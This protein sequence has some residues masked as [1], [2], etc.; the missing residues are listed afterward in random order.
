MT[1]DRINPAHYRS[2]PIECIEYTQWLNFC[3]G[4]AFKY[5]WRHGRKNGLE[6]LKKAEWYLR[7]QMG[8]A[9]IYI[10][11]DADLFHFRLAQLRDCDF[12]NAARL[13]LQNIW[14]AAHDDNGA[15]LPAALDCVRE[16]IA[17]YGKNNV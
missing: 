3:L 5:I 17:D 7:W 4:N 11:L 1:P 15:Y 6:D 12:P 10:E 16:L 9:P 13:A 14:R 8:E 2:Q